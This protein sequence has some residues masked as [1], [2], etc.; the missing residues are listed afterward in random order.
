MNR[1]SATIASIFALI[2]AGG[3]AAAADLQ[4]LKVL[5]DDVGTGHEAT[6]VGARVARK[7]G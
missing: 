3:S 6:H 5:E 7:G 4:D 1:F 2:L